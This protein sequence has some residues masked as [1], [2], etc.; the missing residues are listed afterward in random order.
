MD[1]KKNSSF[2]PT[3]EIAGL[4]YR[5]GEQDNRI[6]VLFSVDLAV[7]PGE[8]VLVTVRP[9]SGKN[10]AFKPYRRSAFRAKRTPQGDGQGALRYGR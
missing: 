8:V 7:Y 3:I 9:E 4:N 6:Q 10:H 2:E 5:F 1:Q